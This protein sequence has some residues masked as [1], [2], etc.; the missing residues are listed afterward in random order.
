ME[1]QFVPY[2]LAI[3]LKELDFDEECFGYYDGN[4]NLQ[5][6]FNG[7]PE[8]FTKKRMGVSNSIW[9][10][11]ISAPI[12]EQAFDFFRNKYNLRGFPTQK[13]AGDYGF[14]IYMPNK[15]NP[16]GKPFKRLGEFTKHFKTYEEAQLECLKK[17]IEMANKKNK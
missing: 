14:E 10:G 9:V 2:E 15:E 7:K 6:M 4:H 11:W 8:N 5:Y 1:K 16:A 3:K 13:V 17:L 12:L